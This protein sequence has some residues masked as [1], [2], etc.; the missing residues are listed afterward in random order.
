MKILLVGGGSG[1]PVSPLL[2]VAAKIKTTH[3]KAEFLFTGS[4]YGPEAAMVKAEGIPFVSISSG[5]FRRYFSL[6]NFLTPFYIFAGFFGSLSI[7]RKYK[8]SCVF[9]AGS[10]VQVPL[11]WAAWVLRIPIIIH[12]QDIYPSLANKLCSWLATHITVT[13]E[14][15]ALDFS[16]GFGLFYKK[17][18]NKIIVTGNPFRQSLAHAS[19]AEAAKNFHLSG[20]LPVLLVFGGG[21]GAQALNT[22]LEKSLPQLLKTVEIIHATGM[23]KQKSIKSEYPQYHQYPFIK[24]MA[25]AYAAADLVLSRAGLSTITELSNLAKLSIIIPMPESHQELNGRFLSHTGS[26]IVLEQR[27]ASPELL[28]RIIRKVLVD[29]NLQKQLVNN[30]EK[31][32]PRNATENIATIVAR[33]AETAQ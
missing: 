6:Q 7:L 16:T 5:K 8:P 27:D 33:L 12:Q 23:N 19:K 22:L 26:A 20:Q 25:E 11:I 3:P 32:M 29:G 21:T 9:G 15:S 24:N 1:G 13:F 17:P 4:N 2:A 14:D 10:F 30:M 31:I 28:I 18:G